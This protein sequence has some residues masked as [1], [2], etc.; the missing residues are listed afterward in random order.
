MGFKRGFLTEC[1]K[2]AT[3]EKHSCLLLDASPKSEPDIRVRT[4]VSEPNQPVTVYQ[5][6]D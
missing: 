6:A 3:K 4:G 1:F 2:D 5:E